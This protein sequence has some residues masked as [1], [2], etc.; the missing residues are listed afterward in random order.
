MAMPVTE[1]FRCVKNFLN[2]VFESSYSQN[3]FKLKLTE[4]EGCIIFL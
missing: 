4:K 2:V 1:I 3:M